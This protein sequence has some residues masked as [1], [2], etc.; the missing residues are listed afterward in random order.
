MSLA[1]SSRESSTPIYFDNG[2][3]SFPKPPAVW[4]AMSQFM[5]QVGA[6]PGRSGHRLS[7]EA[8]RIVYNTR[9]SLA[10]LFNLAD[11][12]QVVF[13]LNATEALN[14][15]V[16]GLLSPGD[17]VITGAMEHNSVMRPLREIEKTGVKLTVVGCSPTGELDPDD[18]AKSIRTAT[19]LVILTHA[20]NVTGG[21]MPIRDVG[22]L[23][24]QKGILFAVDAAQTAGCAPIDMEADFIDL[25]AFTGHK[26][27][28]GPQGTGGLAIGGQVEMKTFKPLK[29]GGTGSRSEYEIQPDFLPDLLESGTP[30]S[31]GIAGLGAGV[32]FVLTETP[33][34]VHRRVSMLSL[35]LINGISGIPGLGLVGDPRPE[36]MVSTVSFNIHGFSPS[37]VGLKLDDDY[38]ILC[39]VGLHCA[40]AAHRTLGTFPQ[41]TV[42]F[43]LGYLNSESEIDYAVAALAEI[44]RG[45]TTAMLLTPEQL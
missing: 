18:V 45:G 2:A 20:S 27:L 28:F 38:N 5:N 41:G 22:R 17:H 33:A 43:G 7:I 35:R 37:E 34:R 3:T 25:L 24:R 6:N 44:A 31:V 39:R 19:R 29:Q 32:D 13:T 1:S 12:L 16:K 14:L 11:P 23:C 4:E 15:V 10:R 36:R 30:N 9:E 26:A 42:R 8:A 40:P 21:L